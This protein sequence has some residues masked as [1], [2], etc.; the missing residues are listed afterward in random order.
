M[1]KFLPLLIILLLSLVA[2]GDAHTCDYS[3]WHTIEA[4]TCTVEGREYR[5]CECGN[6][7]RRTI[8]PLPHDIISVD[9]KPVSCTEG[10]YAAFEYCD[11]CSYSTFGGELPASHDIVSVEGRPPT[12]T[13]LGYD[14]YEYCKRCENYNT[15]VEISATG[16]RFDGTQCTN[17]S[18]SISAV[19]IPAHTSYVTDLIAASYYVADSGLALLEIKGEGAIPDFITS[20]F[21]DLSPT[22]LYIG[23][24]ITGIGQNAFSGMSTLVSVTLSASVSFISE[25]A[26]SDCYRITEVINLSPLPIA[27]DIQHGEIGRYASFITTLSGTRVKFIGDFVFY[28]DGTNYTLVS[29]IGLSERIELPIL[30]EAGT[31]VVRNYAFYNLDFLTSVEIGQHVIHV[32]EYAF[33]DCD[34]LN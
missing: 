14:A 17:C 33:L 9:A 1:K 28:T 25:G 6:T 26:F 22:H 5:S 29:Y 3:E 20:P 27:Y 11:N 10:G 31:Y 2:C 21:S 13:D 8:S 4:P 32:G 16:H 19:T 24:G 30:D 23:E 15:Y 12:C 7:E 34:N 18:T